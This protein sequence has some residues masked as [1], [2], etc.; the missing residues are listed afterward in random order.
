MFKLVALSSLGDH[1][2]EGEKKGGRGRERDMERRTEKRAEGKGD[3]RTSRAGR[4]KV[5]EGKGKALKKE[6]T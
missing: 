1:C 4:E 2:N 5:R 3:R 6:Q